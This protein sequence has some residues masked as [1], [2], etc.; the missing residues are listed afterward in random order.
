MYFPLHSFSFWLLLWSKINALV[1]FWHIQLWD[2][3]QHH[4]LYRFKWVTYVI[5]GE[6]NGREL[7]I[8]NKS[9]RTPTLI[10]T[11]QSWWEHCCYLQYAKCV[12]LSL[13]HTVQCKMGLFYTN[14]YINVCIFCMVSLKL[15][16]LT[17]NSLIYCDVMKCTLYSIK[18]NHG[19]HII[20][21]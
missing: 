18:T 12:Y 4:W 21:N 20:S 5:V 16:D 1:N 7:E 13:L 17:H 11:N 10:N 15:L 6:L 8:T 19:L 9:L 3:F 14:T 2:V